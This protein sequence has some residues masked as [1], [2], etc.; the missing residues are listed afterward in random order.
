MCLR[1]AVVGV[2]GAVRGVR[3]VACGRVGVV[4]CIEGGC[5]CDLRGCGCGCG[6][7]FGYGILFLFT[8]FFFAF[9]DFCVFFNIYFKGFSSFLCFSFSF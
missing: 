1:C 4:A 7:G 6:C 3:C 5:V 9:L 8:V 2:W